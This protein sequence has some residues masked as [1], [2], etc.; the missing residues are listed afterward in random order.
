MPGSHGVTLTKSPIPGLNGID[1]IE[2]SMD[3]ASP[4]GSPR[5]LRMGTRR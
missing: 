2:V 4:L 5:F 1:Q 3:A